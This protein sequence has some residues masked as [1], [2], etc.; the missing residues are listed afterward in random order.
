MASTKSRTRPVRTLVVLGALIV[1]LFASIFAGTQLDAK[2]EDNPGGASWSPE[3][4]LDLQGGTQLILSPVTDDG[5]EVTDEDINQSIAVIRQR[6][7]SSGVA[8]AEIARQGDSNIV[9]G[10]PGEVSQETIDLIVTPAQMTFRPVLSVGSPLP[11]EDPDAETE[12]PSSE[13]SADA[14]GDE[15]ADAATEDSA[16]ATTEDAEADAE[17]GATDA[18][19]E[20]APEPTDPSD[21]AQITPEVQ[22]EFDAL[23]CTDPTNLVG[24]EPSDPD[25]PLVTCDQDGFAK[26]ILGP[27]EVEG[28]DIDHATSGLRTNSQGI[29][30]NEWAV[31]LTF[32]DEGADTFQGVS[33]R[34][35]GLP[36]PQNQF[37]IVLDGLVISAPS[38]NA[39]ITNGQ[40]EISGNFTR[41]SSATLASQLNFGALPLTF[42]VQSQEQISA[43]LG[44][45]QLEKGLIAGLIGLALVAVYSL[46]QYRGLGLVTVASLLIAGLIT[47]GVI[48]LLSWTYGYRLSLPGVAGLIV[49]IG[50]TAD[51]FIVY[52]E[53]VR[54]ELRDGRGLTAAVDRGWSRARRTIVASDAVNFLAAAILYLLAVGGV[55]GFAFTL[56]LTTLVDLLVV[57]LFTH[58]LLQLLAK[59]KFFGE[60]HPGSGLDPR[61]L[62]VTSVRY[63]G[64][65]TTRR[66]KSRDDLL[67]LDDGATTDASDTPARLP[68]PATVGGGADGMTIAERRA[69]RRREADAEPP[70]DGDGTYAQDEEK[71]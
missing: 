58:P 15:S 12:T 23:D 48:T 61:R 17:D 28:S 14:T 13:E 41:E 34:L 29:Q 69:A 43:T 45:D 4:A 6:I 31:N 21:L 46:F 52:F 60:G 67:S 66:A 25:A 36:S 11:A 54:D 18:A 55:Q 70:V 38:M 1:A 51:S 19:T 26:Y 8:E 20:P 39:V 57:F 50:I 32:T 65:G 56:G 40:A 16:D 22:A 68:Q 49:A 9:V 59:T 37:G 53:R 42:E 30:T 10:I 33:E 35:V 7:D 2:S 63:A 3:L 71:N 5:Q 24:G 64:R 44:A 27:V 62:G 47:Y